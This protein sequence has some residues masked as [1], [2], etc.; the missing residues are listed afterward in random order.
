LGKNSIE[1]IVSSQERKKK[2]RK[3]ENGIELR[4]RRKDGE[5]YLYFDFKK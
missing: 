1:Y 2:K 4:K 3:I 5:N